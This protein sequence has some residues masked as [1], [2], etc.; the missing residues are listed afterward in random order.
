MCLNLYFSTSTKSYSFCHLL[1]TPRHCIMYVMWPELEAVTDG[2]L[3]PR[4]Q[5]SASNSS[6]IAFC[7]C[8]SVLLEGTKEQQQK[9][10][11]GLSWGLCQL[12][13][14][15]HLE[16]TLSW[17]MLI[18]SLV[19]VALS[20]IKSYK[21]VLSRQLL[22]LLWGRQDDDFKQI[23]SGIKSEVSHALAWGSLLSF[24]CPGC[25]IRRKGG[26]W[27]ISSL[28]TLYHCPGSCSQ[29]DSIRFKYSQI[30]LC[31]QHFFSFFYDNFPYC[32][33]QITDMKAIYMMESLFCS[34]FDGCSPSWQGNYGSKHSRQ[35]PGPVQSK[36]A[37]CSAH[38]LGLLSIQFSSQQEAAH[39]LGGSFCRHWISPW[40][41]HS[42]TDMSKEVPPRWLWIQSRW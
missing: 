36:E 3:G 29:P 13:C 33:D 2:E 23:L 41:C 30:S 18:S 26:L 34:W 25:K 22:Y 21:L 42:H 4:S 20:G 7:L 24:C 31:L 1:P 40:K 38:G 10:T 19:I 9:H 39:I 12:R 32:C 16:E 28:N 35:S 8:G 6:D 37:E 11:L 17:W 14:V 5:L 15:T 27:D